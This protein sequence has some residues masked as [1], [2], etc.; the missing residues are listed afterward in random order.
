M[1]GYDESAEP[2]LF[3]NKQ[4][5]QNLRLRRLMKNCLQRQ[6]ANRPDFDEI[7]RELKSINLDIFRTQQQLRFN[8]TI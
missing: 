2:K 4:N 1:I 8:K 6:P 3:L 7:I 5:C